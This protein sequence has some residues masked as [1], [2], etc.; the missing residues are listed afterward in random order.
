M[1]GNTDSPNNAPLVMGRSDGLDMRYVPRY[2]LMR[3]ESVYGKDLV[4]SWRCRVGAR[5]V[6]CIELLRSLK[7]SSMHATGSLHIQHQA[8]TVY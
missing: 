8:V 7:Y 2:F 5:K 6:R 4:G 1:A 3:M